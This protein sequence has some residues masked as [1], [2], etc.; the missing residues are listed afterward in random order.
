MTAFQIHRS[1][2]VSLSS[3]IRVA[4]ILLLA[5]ISI[6]CAEPFEVTRQ[7]APKA[8]SPPPG[9]RLLAAMVPTAKQAWFFKLSGKK[10]LIEAQSD[11]FHELLKSLTMK[12]G[13]PV[14]KTPK[15]WTEEPGTGMRKA[16]FV[17]ATGEKS[18]RAEEYSGN[19][20]VNSKL[21]CTVIPLPSTGVLANVNRWRK[22]IGLPGLSAEELKPEKG[23]KGD[24]NEFALEDG[25]LVTWVNL[26]GNIIGGTSPP[27]ADMAGGLGPMQGDMPPGHPDAPVPPQQNDNQQGPAPA[28]TPGPVGPAGPIG[29]PPT[30]QFRKDSIDAM[31][32]EIPSHWA[33]GPPRQFREKTWNIVLHGQTAEASISSLAAGAADLTANVNRWRGQID[34]PASTTDQVKESLDPIKIDGTAGHVAV[35]RGPK[36][37]T[38]GAIVVHG[39][40]GWFLKLTG[41]IQLTAAEEAN[42][43]KFLETIRFK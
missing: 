27:F 10:E 21:E 30:V 17:I 7:R 37:T 26:E 40:T 29:P 32:Y 6:G 3:A 36:K 20:G 35:I 31:S 23:G 8:K 25:T 42:F 41:D 1:H 11:A 43:R 34:M 4:T 38:V 14:W 18:S 5:T 24:L 22:Q 15:G 2:P 19:G 13:E 28:V 16:T 39:D 9:D 12:D 33:L